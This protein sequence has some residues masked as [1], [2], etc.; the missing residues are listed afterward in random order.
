M[1]IAPLALFSVTALCAHV[2]ATDLTD[3]ET[4]WLSAATPVLSY[5]KQQKLPLDVIVQPQPT[6]GSS[7]IAMGFVDGRCKLVLSM[8]GNPKA[9]AALR[10]VPAGLRGAVIETMTAHEVGHCWRHV[11]GAWN[12]LPAGFSEVPVT[13]DG[14]A[15]G[16]RLRR[17]MRAT[18]REEGFADLV[19]LAWTLRQR[20]QQYAE[21]YR[22]LE[23]QRRHPGVPGNHHDTRAWIRLA[24]DRSAFDAGADGLFEQARALWQQG[25]LSDDD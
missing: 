18:R 4:G 8:R 7:P 15:E 20:P 16:E 11:H 13:D 12:S 19:G 6:P 21:V 1:R 17:D 5:A 10:D 2:E 3:I 14:D 23:Q 9:D 22:W 25:L 24:R